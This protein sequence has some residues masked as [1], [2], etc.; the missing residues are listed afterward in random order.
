MDR[1]RWVRAVGTVGGMVGGSRLLGALRDVLMASWFG[2]HPA[3]SAF[4]VAFTIPNLFRRLFGEGALSSSL[5]PVFMRLREQEGDASAWTLANRVLTFALVLLTTICLAGM[6]G[7]ALALNWTPSGT[8]AQILRLTLGLLPYMVFICM[9]ALAAGLLN[10]HHRFAWPAAAPWI[11]NLVWILAL[12]VVV[13]RLGGGPDRQILG[14]VG[15]ILVAGVL[16][17]GSQVPVLIRVD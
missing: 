17:F 7:I 2:T 6:A 14:V 4:V 10:S 3:M 15:G 5:V 11:L 9:T 12:L 1:S 13:P 16:Q 8:T